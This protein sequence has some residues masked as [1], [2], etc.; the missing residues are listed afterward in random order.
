MTN[1]IDIVGTSI[2]TPYPG[3]KL[4]D[5]CVANNIFD[6]NK[7]DYEKLSM[8]KNTAYL[9][10]RYLPKIIFKVLFF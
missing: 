7:I 1:P 4:W 3:T 8:Q 5:Y 6:P 10:N 2:A 9:N